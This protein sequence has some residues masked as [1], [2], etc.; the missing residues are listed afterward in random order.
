MPLSSRIGLNLVAQTN[1]LVDQL[2]F[3]QDIYQRMAIARALYRIFG[4][5]EGILDGGAINLVDLTTGNYYPATC[6]LIKDDSDQIWVFDT[7]VDTLINFDNVATADA[8][9]Y[10]QIQLSP[11]SAPAA[12]KG[13]IDGINFIAYDTI[14]AAPINSLKL[15]TGTVAGGVFTA[16]AAAADL[17]RQLLYTG[18]SLNIQDAGGDHDLTFSIPADW[19]ANRDYHFN[20]AGADVD[21]LIGEL[22]TTRIPF[23]SS[24]GILT[25]DSD[26]V[27]DAAAN[28][29]KL[30]SATKI[31]F[32]A[33]A[34]LY[35]QAAD[36]LAS[37][38]SLELGGALTTTSVTL[39][40]LIA[41]HTLSIS[42]SADLT[43][44]RNYTFIDAGGDANIIV[45]ALGNKRVAFAT[46][47][48]TL[49]NSANFLFDTISDELQLGA[50]TKINIG[51]DSNL[52]RSAAH[53]L[54]TDDN[55]IVA[56]N[57][58]VLGSLKLQEAGGADL[59][60]INSAALGAARTYTIQDAG[61]AANILVAQTLTATRIPYVSSDGVLT[62]SANLVFDSVGNEL[63]L[64]TATKILW[65]IDT[66]L[67]RSGADILKTDDA[68]VANTIT[69]LTNINIQETGG[70]E[71][72][73]IDA[74]ASGAART[75]TIQDA[76][77][78]GNLLVAQTLTATR[79]PYV[80]S[81]GVLT[82]SANLAYDSA[83]NE[84]ELGSATKILFGT[85][86]NNA[87]LY[88]S[89]NDT[90]KTDDK[91]L[92]ASDLTTLGS[93]KIQI[94]LV[95]GGTDLLTISTAPMV[96][97][98]TYTLQDAGAA[99]NILVAQT[100]T[101]TRVPLV[102]V[103]GVLTDSANLIFDANELKLGAATKIN[104]GTDANLYRDSAHV[105][106]TDDSL[107]VAV[108]LTALGTLK[109][110][111]LGG[112][113]DL[114]SIVAAAS[115]APRTYTIQDAGA[116]GNLL[117]AQTLTATYIPY[118]SS[119]GVL[120]NSANLVFDS[121]GNELELGSATKILFGTD[122][123]S[124]NLYRS[125][126]DTLKT[127]DDL[128]VG[129]NA[130]V[131]GSLKLQEAGGL[132]LLTINS[133]ALGAAR[134]YTLQDAGAAANILVAQTLT[135]T[136][137][138]YVS[139]DGVLTNSA[140]LVYDS[141]GNELELGA[142]TKLLF[143]VDTNL[144]RSAANTLKTD[145]TLIAATALTT[146]GSLNIQEAGGGVELLTINSAA[147]GAARTYT[148]QDAGA[149]GNILVAQTLTA[150]RVPIVSADGILT[151]STNFVF[152][153]AN[154]ELDLGSATKILFGTDGNSVNL[155]RSANDTLKTDDSLI[156]ATNATVLGS[157]KLQESGGG[158]DL[159][160]FSVA[161][162]AAARTYTLQDAGA[163]A[164]ILVAQTL[165]ATR[166]PLVSADGV[167][168]DSAN[169]IFSTANNELNLGSATKLVIG[170]DT[171][172]YRNDTNI[173]KTDDSLIV[174]GDLTVIGSLSATFSLNK[175]VFT[176]TTIQNIAAATGITAG[177]IASNTLIRIQGD[178]A[179]ISITATP[180]IAAGSDG[181]MI[182]LEG[183]N[184]VN[185]VTIR[186][187][188][189]LA[190][191]GIELSDGIDFVMGVGDTL[192]LIYNA[193]TSKWNEVN[194]SNN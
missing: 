119:D 113:A 156:V 166:V 36:V 44:N 191:S 24:P 167:L 66:N 189:N 114:I 121:V 39:P 116:S 78:S 87:N 160:T 79:I 83:G 142:A 137:I 67:Y 50:A 84:L 14:D 182:I 57:L 110:Q 81:D 172:L 30:G 46:N 161:A 40:D 145:G 174:A 43:G 70:L 141:V 162:L 158:S 173:L 179:P 22:T 23:V 175:T 122:A 109:I 48:A 140:N 143:D 91:F 149:A 94:G 184:N 111:E 133:A 27:Y 146:L 127:D 100:L 37:D 128:I 108:D 104:I 42:V 176:P 144:Y 60:T 17:F 194:R 106:K 90:L 47:A 10:A 88:R 180:N 183:S 165:T 186:D 49:T 72:I 9:L 123:N 74:A 68:F 5:K 155:Y 138:P 124:V 115:A 75:Y 15:G 76:G 54:K 51:T 38:D 56:L 93:L 59:L 82:N 13:D 12:A 35:R 1:D 33:D 154:N 150:T 132:E 18:V 168:T 41:D 52:Y 190:N 120:T 4:N 136:R 86:A 89:A 112:G 151:D 188:A 62:N 96:A 131:L 3:N 20:D 58:S 169:F 157:L 19:V 92:V 21:V 45:G 170:A 69:T 64:G 25:D 34:N 126:N 80:S 97:A 101:T 85:D 7:D 32:G 98:R 11:T 177:M 159:L 2:G 77:A 125:A 71:L 187:S 181:Q 105:L 130:T 107:I 16:F 134:T 53:T 63:E 129:A 103:D 163:A 135:A 55:L 117:V 171:N 193:T 26:F 8:H 29:L 164:N 31:L 28:E 102:S 152:S 95:G 61:A 178:A 99:A 118:V 148:L 185:T 6:L 73:T 147:L 65:D 139:A 153:T 192:T